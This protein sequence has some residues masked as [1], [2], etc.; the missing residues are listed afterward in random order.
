M[1]IFLI[2]VSFVNALLYVLIYA[3][4]DTILDL[5]GTSLLSAGMQNFFKVI[6]LI[7]TGFCI[8]LMS[9]LLLSPGMERSRFDV[10][11]LLLLG[12][13]PFIFLILSPGSVTDL[14]ASRI[15]G[16]NESIRELLFYLFSRQT[17]W[18]IW[19]GFAAGTSVRI[20]FGRRRHKHASYTLVEKKNKNKTG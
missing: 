2:I 16:N 10:K 4:Y 20:H 14:V 15:F 9:M 3:Y 5:L 8:G 18:S 13:I 12:I 17:L 19:L 11:N 1:R 6:V 7:A